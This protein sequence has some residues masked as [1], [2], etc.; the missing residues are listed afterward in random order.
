MAWPARGTLGRGGRGAR[1]ASSSLPPF[2]EREV[3][4]TSATAYGDSCTSSI[5]VRAPMRD[6]TIGRG[7]D[8]K[9]TS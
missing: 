7:P 3:Q 5:G 6:D 9:L 2:W 1:Q 4:A 8:L